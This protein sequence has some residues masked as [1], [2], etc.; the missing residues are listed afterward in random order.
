MI[1][2]KCIVA[3]LVAITCLSARAQTAEKIIVYNAQGPTHSGTAQLLKV[4][5]IA[6]QQQNQY[7]FLIEFKNGCEKR[8]I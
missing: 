4:I 7:Q 8:K 6:N 5:E 1:I 2:K 3:T